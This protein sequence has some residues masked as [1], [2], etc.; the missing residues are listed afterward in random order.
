MAN[1]ALRRLVLMLPVLLLVTFGSFALLRLIP[2]SAA[3]IRSGAGQNRADVERLEEQWGLN[4]PIP[5]QFVSWVG[6]V[7]TGDLGESIWTTEPVTDEIKRRFPPTAE[8]ALLGAAF[9]VLVAV[10]AGTLAALNQDRWLDRVMQLLTALGIAVPN[11]VLATL[12]ISLPAIWWGWTPPTGF[13]SVLS[14]PLENLQR[15]ILPAMLLGLAQAAVITR[16]TR[17]SLL[18]VLR[19]DYI[20]TARAKGLTGRTVIIRHGLRNAMMP[21]ITV[22][23]L[24]FAT[25]LGGAVIIETV[26]SIP[27]MGTG[28]LTAIGRRDYDLAQTLVLIFGVVHVLSVFVTDISYMIV[29]PRIKYS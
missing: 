2:G 19:Q 16:L 11:F 18:E 1:Y 3:E 29:D 10:P 20:R 23:G 22:F 21:I 9:A 4:D 28:V 8:L 24:Q 27:G 26:F 6:R 13:V 12:A 17:S 15:L 7:L 25:L 5:V 14:D